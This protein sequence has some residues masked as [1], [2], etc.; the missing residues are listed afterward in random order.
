LPALH[1]SGLATSRKAVDATT[2]RFDIAPSAAEQAVALK[3][4]KSRVHR[5]FRQREGAGCSDSQLL[6]HGIPVCRAVGED[7]KDQA[8]KMALE[9]LRLHT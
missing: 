9:S 6:Y 4:V 2:V 5:A 8:V 3:A 7:G 1:Q